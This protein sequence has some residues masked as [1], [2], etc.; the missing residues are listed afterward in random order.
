MLANDR[1]KAPTCHSPTL[2]PGMKDRLLNK[3]RANIIKLMRYKVKA[4]KE[5]KEGGNFAKYVIR[6]CASLPCTL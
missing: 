2:P 1:V 5:E 3:R 4:S 6:E